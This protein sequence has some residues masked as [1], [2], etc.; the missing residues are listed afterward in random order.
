[1]PHPFPYQG[2]KRKIAPAV[3]SRM[4]AR[5]GTLYEPFAG[6]GAVTIAVAVAGRAERFAI[7]D[8]HAPLMRLW[9]AILD[10]AH[11]LCDRYEALWHDQQANSRAFYDVVR[12]RFN[13]THEPHDLLYL[14]AR[15]VKAAIRYNSRGEFNNSP[16]KRRLGMKPDNMRANVAAVAKLLSGRTTATVGDFAAAIE[17]ATPDDVVYMDPPYQGV[18]DTHNHRY[19]KGLDLPG[20]VAALE[21]LNERGIPYLV[22]Y[23]GR[24]GDKVHGEPLPKHLRLR[25]EEVFAGLSTQATLLGKPAETYESLYLSEALVARLGEVKPL[26]G[27]RKRQVEATP[28]LDGL[29]AREP[30][31]D[32]VG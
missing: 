11:G 5:F 32:V 19:L 30:L 2:S 15:C 10:D 27:A 23:D 21:R 3:L 12:D 26:R 7:N 13:K 16:D 31:A 8:V 20:F 22:S 25:H 9:G 29:L 24:T 17:P 6:S 28:L 18:S 14:L 1:M 4:P